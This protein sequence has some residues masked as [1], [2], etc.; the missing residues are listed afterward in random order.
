MHIVFYCTGHREYHVNISSACWKD[1]YRL[2]CRRHGSVN[3][4]MYAKAFRDDMVR[5]YVKDDTGRIRT[6]G[7]MHGEYE[8][9]A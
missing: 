3:G 6:A 8:G 4:F 5:C 9:P 7:V 2:V 1:A